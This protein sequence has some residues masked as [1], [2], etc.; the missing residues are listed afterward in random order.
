MFKCINKYINCNVESSRVNEIL[1]HIQLAHSFEANFKIECSVSGCSKIFRRVQTL[2][3]HIENNHS[4]E[5]NN[6]SAKNEQCYCKI[7][8]QIF[9][10]YDLL[11]RDIFIA[12]LKKKKKLIVYFLTANLVVILILVIRLIYLIIIEINKTKK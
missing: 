11:I 2:K 9:T 1:E 4:K 7:C 5:N 10:S 12:I 6:E 3:N 8:D